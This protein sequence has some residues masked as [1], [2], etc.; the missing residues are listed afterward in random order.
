MKY[1]KKFNENIEEQ[2]YKQ[3]LDRIKECFLEFE[4]NGWHWISDVSYPGISVWHSPQF[5]CRMMSKEE[6][7]Q[8]SDRRDL[9]DWTGEINSDSEITWDTKELKGHN[10]TKKVDSDNNTTWSMSEKKEEFKEGSKE[11]EEAE[12]FL[13]AVKRL[14]S[15]IGIGFKFSYNNRGGEKRIIIQGSI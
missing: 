3:V 6:V 4:D 8:P 12:D 11:R 1:L 2:I 13:V 15:E 9:L 10:L 7:Y 14:Q 5:N